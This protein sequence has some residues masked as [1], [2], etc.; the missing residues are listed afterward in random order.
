M[1]PKMSFGVPQVRDF[2]A[3]QGCVLTV[4]GYDYK[5]TSATVPDLNNIQIK[6]KKV[7]EIQSIDDLDGFVSLSGFKTV[8]EWWVQIRRFCKGRMWLYRVQ[9][10]DT[11]L[12]RQEQDNEKI[13]QQ[14][15]FTE[16]NAWSNKEEIAEIIRDQVFDDT[17]IDQVKT[18]MGEYNCCIGEMSHPRDQIDAQHRY[19]DP[20]MIDL[21]PSKDAVHSKRLQ[22][23]AGAAERRRERLRERAGEQQGEITRTIPRTG[24]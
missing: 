22:E 12:S 15:M 13:E 19:H 24:A 11:W 23:E 18:S 6:R 5:T 2:L 9:I 16:Q 8:S 20:Y 10:D 7:C 17:P 4:R 3:Y 21:Q 14:Q 1:T